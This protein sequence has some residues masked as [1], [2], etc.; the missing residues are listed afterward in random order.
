MGPVF[1][2]ANLG[3]SLYMSLSLSLSDFVFVALSLCL[4]PSHEACMKV[5]QGPLVAL[6][7]T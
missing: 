4:A 5:C 1:F 7:Q 6:E 2:W 3:N